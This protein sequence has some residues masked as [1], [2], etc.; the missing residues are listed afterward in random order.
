MC[1]DVAVGG[2]PECHQRDLGLDDP[3]VR[4]RLAG[5]GFA[6]RLELVEPLE[7]PKAVHHLLGEK[8][9]GVAVD[10][11]GGFLYNCFHNLLVFVVIWFNANIT[12]KTL[13][14]FN[15]KLKKQ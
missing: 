11:L 7:R 9:P 3:G 13:S 14:F 8:N 1:G 5:E 4:V 15:G 10:I 2:L 6:R 12:V